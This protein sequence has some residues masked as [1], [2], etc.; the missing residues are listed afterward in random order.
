[1][2]PNRCDAMRA[3]MDEYG[4]I[5]KRLAKKYGCELV[6]LQAMFDRYFRYRHSTCIAWDRIHPNQMGATLIA[7]EFLRHCGFVFEHGTDA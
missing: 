4:A 5:V 6:D 3:R 2:E 7:R 1:M